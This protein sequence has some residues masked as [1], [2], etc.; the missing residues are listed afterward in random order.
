MEPTHCSLLAGQAAGSGAS[1]LFA[2]QEIFFVRP[3]AAQQNFGTQQ[4]CRNVSQTQKGGAGAPGWGWRVEI[5][6]VEENP[7]I[8]HLLST[9]RHNRGGTTLLLLFCVDFFF[10]LTAFVLTL[11][12][13]EKDMMLGVLYYCPNNNDNRDWALSPRES[14]FERG[15]A[16]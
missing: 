12:R 16:P 2:H 8:F 14:K 9:P 4:V 11:E 15:L 13:Q 10:F 6:A 7:R 1:G 3:E 5:V